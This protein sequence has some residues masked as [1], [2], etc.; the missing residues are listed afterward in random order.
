MWFSYQS[1]LSGIKSQ[2]HAKVI[3]SSFLEAVNFSPEQTICICGLLTCQTFFETSNSP[4]EAETY[5]VAAEE[6][7]MCV[8][9]VR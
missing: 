7:G 2:K 1:L 8:S 6:R 5:L 3:V 9:E 4:I